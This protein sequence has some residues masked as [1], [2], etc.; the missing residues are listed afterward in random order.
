M[1]TRVGGDVD[2]L[3]LRDAQVGGGEGAVGGRQIKGSQ[4]D[5]AVGVAGEAV[6]VGADADADDAIVILSAAI[7]GSRGKYQRTRTQNGGGYQIYCSS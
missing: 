6:G 4:N 1:A 5:P 2:S 7:W 3:H